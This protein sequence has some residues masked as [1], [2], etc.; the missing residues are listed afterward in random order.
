MRCRCKLCRVLAGLTALTALW[1]GFRLGSMTMQ[2]MLDGAPSTAPVPFPTRRIVVATALVLLLCGAGA[3]ALYLRQKNQDL[4]L[5]RA[6]TGGEPERGPASIA[7]YGC[8][9]CHAI[10]GVPGADGQ[11]GPPLAGLRK[12]VYIGG[13][14]RNTADNLAAWITDPHAF[15]PG[16]AMPITGISPGEARDVAAYLYTQ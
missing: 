14:A 16:T 8:G 3:A 9:G 4:A 10:A 1:I 15:S 11:V 12:R 6:L 5:A 7:R 2:R 13:V